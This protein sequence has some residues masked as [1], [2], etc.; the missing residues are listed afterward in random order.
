MSEVQ[1]PMGREL[2]LSQITVRN[3]DFILNVLGVKQRSDV[4]IFKRPL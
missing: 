4:N 1:G 2:A 3:L